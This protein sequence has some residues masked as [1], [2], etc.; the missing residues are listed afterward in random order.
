[1]KNT[2]DYAKIHV[3]GICAFVLLFV[4]L[5][6]LGVSVLPGFRGFRGF[7][8]SSPTEKLLV[9]ENGYGEYV[10]GCLRTHL[11]CVVD[12][13]KIDKKEILRPPTIENSLV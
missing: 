6:G 9:L 12:F 7:L 5:L 11:D 1:M 4:C 8:T 10:V 2:K 13:M 3:T